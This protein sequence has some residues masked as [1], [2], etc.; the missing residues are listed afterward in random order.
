MNTFLQTI[1][2]AVAALSLVSVS[3]K[4]YD[5]N[6]FQLNKVAVNGVAYSLFDFFKYTAIT[7]LRIILSKKD[8]CFIH[9][10]RK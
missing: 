4:P 5:Y 8:K 10:I 1:V 7:T 9:K 6:S 2:F 3:G